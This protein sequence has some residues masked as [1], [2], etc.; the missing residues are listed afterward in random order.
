MPF[1][2]IALAFHNELQY[3]NAD[4]CIN[5]GSDSVT[6]CKN[7]VNFGPVIQEISRLEC[8]QQ[9]SQLVCL[10]AFAR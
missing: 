7:L 4:V 3:S 2:F 10:T 9:A 6:S 5:S 8:V 1:L